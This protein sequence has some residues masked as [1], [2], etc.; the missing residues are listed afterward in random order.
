MISIFNLMQ[1]SISEEQL[2]YCERSLKRFCCQFENLYGK[3]YMTANVH[4]LLHLTQCVRELGPLWAY[5]CFHFESQNGILKSL[6]Y[7]T[8]HVEKQIIISFSYY[9]NLPSAAKELYQ[10]TAY[11][12]KHLINCIFATAFQDTTIRKYL[13]ESICLKSLLMQHSHRLK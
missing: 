12:C 5:S 1:Q 6:V 2:E 13:T 10:R 8:Q 11:T 9:K 4:L 3:R 7:G